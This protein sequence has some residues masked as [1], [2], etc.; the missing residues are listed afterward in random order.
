MSRA[1]HTRLALE[2]GDHR[3]EV[4]H[5]PLHALEVVVGEGRELV[6]GGEE[7]DEL[8]DAAL[9]EA[10]LGEDHILRELEL[11]RLMQKEGQVGGK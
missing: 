4:G 9:E 7:V 11:L 3:E 5:Q 10:R 8:L 1:R 2:L 6:D